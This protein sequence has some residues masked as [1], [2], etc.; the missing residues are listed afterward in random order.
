MAFVARRISCPP[1]VDTWPMKLIYR[2]DEVAKFREL[3]AYADA[4]KQAADAVL[5]RAHRTAAEL[6]ARGARDEALRRRRA[7]AAL[8]ARA[9]VLE[10]AYRASR[11]ALLARLEAVLD[12]ALEAAL[13]RIALRVPDE[14]RIAVVVDELRRQLH[15]EPGGRL[16]MSA[17]DEATCRAAG[18][19]FPWPVQVDET[20]AA[21]TCRLSSGGG[22]WVL[23]FGAL[24]E[25]LTNVAR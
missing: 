15:A 11:E 5:E 13:R 24:V 10:A 16:H 12:A 22:E 23:A 19:A 7:D 3:A 20:L 18:L 8:L 17:D 21:G 25:S 14:Q 4:A 2:A 9:G 1:G 6:E